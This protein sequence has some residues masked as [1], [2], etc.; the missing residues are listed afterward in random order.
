MFETERW[1]PKGLWKNCQDPN[2]MLIKENISF[3]SGICINQLC[4]S[5]RWNRKRAFLGLVK[6]ILTCGLFLW[7]LLYYQILL[8]TNVAFLYLNSIS[9]H[10]VLRIRGYCRWPYWWS[11]RLHSE[12]DWPIW[13]VLQAGKE[14][15]PK[16]LPE[17]NVVKSWFNLNQSWNQK[18]YCDFIQKNNFV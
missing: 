3:Q 11:L 18:Y 2:E 12:Q 10:F 14:A 15:L 5:C 8:I 1:K 17:L 9:F 13:T 4:L 16:K 7:L 6:H